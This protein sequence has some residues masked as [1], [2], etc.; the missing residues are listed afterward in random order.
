[1][2]D[3]MTES[4]RYEMIDAWVKENKPKRYGHG[5][6]PEGEEPPNL[7][8]WGKS[9]KKKNKAEEQAALDADGGGAE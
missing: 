4:A 7:S 3:D 9:R 2:F 6:R 1:M 5:E 8:V